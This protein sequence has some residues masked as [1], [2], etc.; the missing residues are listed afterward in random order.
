MKRIEAVAAWLFGAAFTLLGLAVTVETVGRKL[1]NYSLQGVDELGGYIL[2]VG[3]ALAFCVALTGRGHIRIDI[4][5]AR[6]PGW[7]RIAMNIASILSL[8]LCA[9]ALL[10]MGWISL[11]DT[12][13]FNSTAQTPWATPLRYPQSVWVVSLILF[14]GLACWAAASIVSLMLRR[15]WQRIDLQFGPKSTDDEL[16]EELADLR[17]RGGG[18]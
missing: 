16:Q 5:H 14:A 4:L 13:A 12:L 3:A 2:A 17:K 10:V 6:L 8:A 15:Q 1:F 18:G 7:L 11:G 9:L